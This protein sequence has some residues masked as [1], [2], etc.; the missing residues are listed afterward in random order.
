MSLVESISARVESPPQKNSVSL[1]KKKNAWFT[2]GMI[3]RRDLKC[4]KSVNGWNG[5]EKRDRAK[6]RDPD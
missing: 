2:F 3:R 6:R 5:G 4:I 1:W